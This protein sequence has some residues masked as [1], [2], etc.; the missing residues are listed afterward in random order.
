M[1]SVLLRGSVPAGGDVPRGRGGSLPSTKGRMTNLYLR[2]VA[3]KII[4]Y[5]PTNKRGA[6]WP[7][8][9]KK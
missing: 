6:I 9:K 8:T 2:E 1:K 4:S 5:G 3:K 7:T